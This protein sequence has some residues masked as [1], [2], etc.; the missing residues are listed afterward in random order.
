MAPNN[1]KGDN[2]RDRA[3]D[4]D[5]RI[6]GVDKVL[7]L[8]LVEV[9]VLHASYGATVIERQTWTWVWAVVQ[10]SNLIH[11]CIAEHNNIHISA[12][13]NQGRKQRERR[14]PERVDLLTTLLIGLRCCVLFVSP[15]IHLRNHDHIRDTQNDVTT[16][17]FDRLLSSRLRLSPI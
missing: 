7:D 2:R 13:S 17:F 15:T 16:H 9:G 5:R 6:D 14:V 3:K 8:V 10:L 4:K 11:V 12:G 1:L